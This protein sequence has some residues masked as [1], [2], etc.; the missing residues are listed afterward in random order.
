MMQCLLAEFTT[1]LSVPFSVG[2]FC[3]FVYGLFFLCFF[4]GFVLINLLP[5]SLH[6]RAVSLYY[7]PGVNG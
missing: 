2:A 5:V 7:C 6:S 1:C 3:F 4:S